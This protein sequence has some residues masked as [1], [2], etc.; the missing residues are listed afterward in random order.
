MTEEKQ[1]II[2][3][4][5]CRT[6]YRVNSEITG[7]KVACKRCQETFIAVH[8]NSPLSSP[9][10][11][12]E[13]AV[14]YNLITSAQLADAISAQHGE[15]SDSARKS[16]E[17]VLLEKGLLTEAQI[18]TLKLTDLFRKANQMSRRLGALAVEKRMITETDLRAALEK[19][20][21]LFKETKTIRFVKDIL[22]EEG[23]LTAA[24]QDELVSAMSGE[25]PAPAK[26]AQ[27][28]PEEEAASTSEVKRFYDLVAS[29]DRMS[30]VLQP[31]TAQAPVLPSVAMR[32]LLKENGITH[33]IIEDDEFKSILSAKKDPT[34]PILIA[35]GTPPK[36][37][38]NASVTY[39]FDTNQK[40]GTL[41]AQGAIDFK[42]KGEVPFVRQGD[43]LVEKTPAQ[44]GVPGFDI[45]GKVLSAPP[46]SDTKLLVG[47]GAE[48]SEDKLK[49]Y[50]KAA[51]QPKISFGGRIA[52]MSELVVRGD[53]D[54]KSG[55]IDFEG[56]VK[57]TGTIQNGFHVK[58]ANLE[59][60]E[61]MGAKITATGT[62]STTGGII[63]ADIK[64]QGDVKAKYIKHATL[65]TFGD[66]IVQK[67]ITDSSINTSGACRITRGKILSS[68]ISAK[69][70]V[71]AVDIGTDLSAPCRLTVG[72]DDHI[73]AEMA[74][75]REAVDRRRSRLE[76]TNR[77]I[78]SL[79]TRQQEIH[80]II[81]ET[82]Q[83]QDR[84]LVKQRSLKQ[85]LDTLSFPDDEEKRKDLN[86]E[87]AA[88]GE[89]AKEAEKS[90]GALFDQQDELTQQTDG[91][92]NQ[93]EQI[94]DDILELN[95]ELES[96]RQ[97]ANTGG[98]PGE[99]AGKSADRWCRGPSSR[100]P[101]PGH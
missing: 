44:P 88:L 48:L 2:V 10:R 15:A 51:G 90:L 84:A 61:I 55:H 79:D 8:K 78:N 86:V 96:I 42:N 58:C 24:D 3:C 38:V 41:G 6:E 29:E 43:L 98:G 36:P 50:A 35:R 32:L 5:R 66:V 26:P 14:K 67:E 1:F 62:V 97:W 87:I 13:L 68:E 74:R 28:I 92:Q 72:V 12:G 80:R 65:S 9:P 20:A 70:G 53:V 40:I 56:N 77:E 33:G 31:K 69:Q 52:V 23:L 22:F 27:T 81:A 57:V 46:V 63:G 93:A 17:A 71:E 39:H 54:L 19:Q 18:E 7:K 91:L 60:K 82:A 95:N 99:P 21:A 25:P 47:A 59:A 34:V 94:Q 89:K 64:A 4:P 49:I 73:E 75:I 83:V 101:I 45:F 85:Q 100:V 76:T 37:G 16:I 30:A 11:L